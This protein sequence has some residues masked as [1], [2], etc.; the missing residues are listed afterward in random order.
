ML[1]HPV[2]KKHIFIS[3]IKNNFTITGKRNRRPLNANI[4][5][6]SLSK[7]PT[8]TKSENSDRKLQ[9]HFLAIINY[10]KYIITLRSLIFHRTEPV[11]LGY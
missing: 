9:V 8:G 1:W 6:G 5:Q 7:T 3:A 4:A 11:T 10:K 2:L